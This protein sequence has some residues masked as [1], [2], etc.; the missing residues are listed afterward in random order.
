[1]EADMVFAY[2][3]MLITT[4]ESF[5]Q[6]TEFDIGVV[7]PYKNQVTEIKSR[8]DAAFLENITIGTAAV[9]QGQEKPVII[10]STVSVGNVSEFAANY[11]RI[12]V[13]LTRPRSL[14]VII[15]HEK[16][17]KKNDHWNSVI[18]YCEKNKAIIHGASPFEKNL[19]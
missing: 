9:L 7:T 10:I 19:N 2:I 14:L 15:G 4:N 3:Q 18:E 16:T 11:R 13:M 5:Q 17:L 1:M 6:V 12:N 8:C